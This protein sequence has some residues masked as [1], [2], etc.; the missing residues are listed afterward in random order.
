M[1]HHH[2]RSAYLYLSR[3]YAGLPFA[4]LRALIAAGLA[5]RFLGALI[6]HRIG[7]GAAPARSAD[8]LD[9]APHPAAPDIR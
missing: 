4:P 6:V 1:L 9:P 7:Q 2:H 5:A 3:R 8:L